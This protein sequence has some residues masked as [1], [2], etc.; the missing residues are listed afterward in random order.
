MDFDGIHPCHCSP[1]AAYRGTALCPWVGFR[2]AAESH[3]RVG[4]LGRLTMAVIRNRGDKIYCLLLFFISTL[5]STSPQP[6]KLL[7]VQSIIPSAAGRMTVAAAAFSVAGFLD[8]GSSDLDRKVSLEALV[9]W[10]HRPESSF[11]VDPAESRM[12]HDMCREMCHKMGARPT[13][14]CSQ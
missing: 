1:D 3:V 4:H 7:S 8:A 13:R 9:G 2:K 5:V 14:T 10:L 12:K 6:R 11:P